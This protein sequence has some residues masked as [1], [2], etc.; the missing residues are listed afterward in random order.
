MKV[1]IIILLSGIFAFL[2]PQ[3]TILSIK[4]NSSEIKG[5]ML[6]SIYQQ[7]MAQSEKILCI[8]NLD[9]LGYYDLKNQ[10][11]TDSKR[12]NYKESEDYKIKYL[13]LEGL[14]SKLI[15]LNY[16]LDFEPDYYDEKSIAINYNPE[17]R[18]F[19]VSN[20]V[21]L[22]SFYDESGF[23]QFDQILFRCPSGIVVTKK[24]INYACVDVIE[25]TISFEIKNQNLVSKIEENKNFLRLLFVFSFTGT[26]ALK[27][28]T[29]NLISSD[30]CFMTELRNVVVYNSRT[31]E[32]YSSYK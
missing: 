15:N 23:I 21:S 25:E 13:E 1:V 3:E 12:T 31:N 27:A 32:I 24:N 9:V 11:N 29:S 18:S 6:N 5:R 16:F 2:N 17:A 7:E 14:R 19:S 28:N 10:Y 8:L 30:Y 20:N 26:V 4:T 22:S